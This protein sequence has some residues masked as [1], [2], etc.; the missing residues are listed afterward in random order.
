[1][2]KCIRK[3][4]HLR[5]S[6]HLQRQGWRK[7]YSETCKDDNFVCAAKQL[8]NGQYGVSAGT[9]CKQDCI[10]EYYRIKSG[11]KQANCMANGQWSTPELVC[12]P[13]PACA[14]DLDATAE[15]RNVKTVSGSCSGG[16]LPSGIE[17]VLKGE[18]CAQECLDE[19]YV[20][21]R[22]PARESAKKNG[23]ASWSGFDLLCEKTPTCGDDLGI[24]GE[25]RNVVYESGSCG[26]GSLSGDV[27]VLKCKDLHVPS[28][29]SPART[30]GDDGQWSG[31][32]FS[33]NRRR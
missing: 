33:A 26:A 11:Q 16:M 5:A 6:A 32:E 28:S 21:Y 8:A 24:F 14:E 23:V 29:G 19:S 27:C 17:G 31:G 7:R 13:V 4:N 9:W 25:D 10:S 15:S 1:M 18:V 12:E 20:W 30:C 22:A 3:S 2:L